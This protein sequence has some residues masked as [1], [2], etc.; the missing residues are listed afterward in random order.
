MDRRDPFPRRTAT[1]ARLL[2]WIAELAKTLPGL[3]RFDLGVFATI[4]EHWKAQLNVEN[5]FNKG[6]WATADEN[7]NISPGQ[8]R[9]L[10]LKVTARF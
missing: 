2:P 4:D 8:S 9:T 7:N 1:P 3:V 6:Y 10:R 5:L